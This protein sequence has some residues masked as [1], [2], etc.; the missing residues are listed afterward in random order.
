MDGEGIVSKGEEE[1]ASY[2]VTQEAQGETVGGGEKRPYLVVLHGPNAGQTFPLKF[3]RCVIGRGADAD[4]VID[5]PGVSRTHAEIVFESWATGPLVRDLGS[6]NGTFCNNRPVEICELSDGDRIRLGVNIVL[7]IDYLDELEE[8]VQT[9]LYEG[10]VRD[11]LTDAFNRRAFNA[12]LSREVAFAMRHDSPLSLLMI[13]ID[14]FK[15]VNDVYGHLTGDLVL[16]GVARIISSLVRVE[17]FFARYGGEEFAVLLRHTETKAASTLATRIRMAVESTPIPVPSGKGPEGESLRGPEAQTRTIRH[18]LIRIPIT[19]SIGLATLNDCNYN[20]AQALV[21]SADKAL[22]RAK[23][24]GRN[25][26][27]IA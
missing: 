23:T 2:M 7:R 3:P 18:K 4:I 1:T 20:T 6:T 26:L 21:E 14:R 22:Y 12:H 24:E 16:V 17:D 10:A 13:D 8:S 15:S 25:R 9:Q 5:D 19:V 27:C 11:G